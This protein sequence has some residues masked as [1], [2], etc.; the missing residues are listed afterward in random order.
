MAG[1]AARRVAVRSQAVLP[2]L[3]ACRVIWRSSRRSG[4][5]H[6]SCVSARYATLCAT[7][8]FAVALRRFEL[9]QC[10]FS[11]FA[12]GLSVLVAEWRASRAATVAADLIGLVDKPLQ[13]SG[14]VRVVRAASA[15]VVFSERC[16]CVAGVSA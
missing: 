3:E 7:S 11:A 9:S 10:E 2:A 5:S 14:V 16:V 8:D 12:L 15:P 4:H 6:R 13:C 1:L